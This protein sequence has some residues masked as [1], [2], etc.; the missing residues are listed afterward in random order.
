MAGRR[1]ID[2]NTRR[3][4][5]ALY[6]LYEELLKKHG[7]Y[8]VLLQKKALYAQLVELPAPEWFISPVQAGRIIQRKINELKKKK[9]KEGS[10]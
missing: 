10:E 1:K 5:K 8:A 4:D 7:K 2:R 9:V 3:R 6:E